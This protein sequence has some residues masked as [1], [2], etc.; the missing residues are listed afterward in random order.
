MITYFSP[1]TTPYGPLYKQAHWVLPIV[2]RLIYSVNIRG[3]DPRHPLKKMKTLVQR[4]DSFDK[5]HTFGIEYKNWRGDLDVKGVYLM[6]GYEK[7]DDGIFWAMSKTVCVSSHYS[8]AERA[9][10]DRIYNN[11][12]VRDGEIVLIN[13]EQYKT[14]VLGD[15]SNTAIFDK[16]E[17]A[18]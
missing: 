3:R 15:Y 14:R 10:I 17:E 4:T 2:V 5:E 18:N 7:D 9:E 8:E 11:E 1:N 16:L 6:Q 12:P 13:G